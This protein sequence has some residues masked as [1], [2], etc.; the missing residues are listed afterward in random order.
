MRAWLALGL[1]IL[2]IAACAQTRGGADGANWSELQASLPEFPKPE[3]Y[4]PLYVSVT[5]P[6]AFFSL[7][8]WS[9][10]IV[11]P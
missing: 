3:N 4:L 5:T 11:S 7:I 1:I 9:T 8:S 10:P 2:P 6:F